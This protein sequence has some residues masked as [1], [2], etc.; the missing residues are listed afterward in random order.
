MFA[1]VVSQPATDGILDASICGSSV[2][3]DRRQAEQASS[4]AQDRALIDG[5]K[6]SR[7]WMMALLGTVLILGACDRGEPTGSNSVM[8]P[9]SPQTGT[10]VEVRPDGQGGT[11]I[12]ESI[13]PGGVPTREEFPIDAA[14]LERL[15]RYRKTGALV[16][17]LSEVREGEVV[18]ISV[19]AAND[20]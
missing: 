9:A 7:R 15:E 4:I 20:E 18:V 8:G 19:D 11:F 16:T 6:R 17:V 1:R 2:V 12:L 5:V 10:L 13:Q 3:T 14:R